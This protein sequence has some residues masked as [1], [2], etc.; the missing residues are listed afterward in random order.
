[1]EVV[2]QHIWRIPVGERFFQSLPPP[3]SLALS[4]KRSR[5]GERN[6]VTISEHTGYREIE[7][8]N[9]TMVNFI[10][11]IADGGN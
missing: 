10:L 5:S 4:M 8:Q 3:S 7:F 1:M 9:S 2:V 11:T 6:S